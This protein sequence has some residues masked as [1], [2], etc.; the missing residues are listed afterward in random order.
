MGTFVNLDIWEGRGPRTLL[1]PRACEK[2]RQDGK[3]TF[4][5][6]PFWAGLGRMRPEPSSLP[7]IKDLRRQ[8]SSYLE[9]QDPKS[10]ESKRL[11]FWYLRDTR[12]EVR[13]SRSLSN[14][15]AS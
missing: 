10:G 8:E 13:E 2:V 15:R 12:S 1:A 4:L 3:G 7:E 11:G 14:T 6:A 5:D 9:S